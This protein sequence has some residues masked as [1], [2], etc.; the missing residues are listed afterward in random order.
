MSCFSDALNACPNL[1]SY[2]SNYFSSCNAGM[3]REEFP[4][5]EFIA[6]EANNMGLRQVVSPGNG[7]VRKVDLLYTKRIPESSV[8]ENQA[9]PNCVATT[10]RGD[11]LQTYD[12]DTTQNQQVEQLIEAS[13]LERNCQ[14][15]PEYFQLQVAYLMDALERK[16]ATQITDDS[17][18]LT[19]NWA[20]DVAGVNASNQLVVKT[21][22]DGTTQELDPFTMQIINRSLRKTGY[23]TSF[24]VFGGDTL[25][26]YFE[27]V[28]SGC[29]AQQGVDLG[30]LFSR[31]GFAVAYDRRVVNAFGGTQNN[32]IV[33]QLGA[34]ALLWYTRSPW[35]DGAPAYIASAGNYFSTTLV[36][37]RLGIPVDLNVKDDCGS[38]SIT[39]TGTVKPVGMPGDMFPAADQYA[40]MVFANEILV[41][42]V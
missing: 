29:C 28:Q 42:N 10:K 20:T 7:K 27:R 8:A 22:K 34:I 18:G 40:G 16:L 19:G 37:P 25:T 12:I 11:C 33:V 23:C 38:V 39:L 13:D 31:F 14:S 26:N 2:L 24:G 4:Y 17:A 32:N 6:S 5:A 21:L 30:D 15:N 36:T 1:Q 3:I 35:K 41:T 9:N